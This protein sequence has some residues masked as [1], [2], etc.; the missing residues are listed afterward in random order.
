MRVESDGIPF[1]KG[2]VNP[3]FPSFAHGETRRYHIC[4]KHLPCVFPSGGAGTTYTNKTPNYG[5]CVRVQNFIG[6]IQKG[7]GRNENERGVAHVSL[8]GP[9]ARRQCTGQKVQMCMVSF[10]G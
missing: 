9:H 2:D 7:D 6:H 5:I 8:S 1:E 4:S 3:Y 10:Q